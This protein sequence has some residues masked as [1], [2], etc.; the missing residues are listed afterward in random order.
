MSGDLLLLE[1]PSADLDPL[2]REIEK[3]TEANAFIQKIQSSQGVTVYQ[4][5]VDIALP[6]ALAILPMLPD[7]VRKHRPKRIKIG[8]F[9]I[10]NPTPEQATQMWQDYLDARNRPA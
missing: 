5:I 8:E 2:K 7:L 9:E 10:E 3:A 4:V 6:I 1:C